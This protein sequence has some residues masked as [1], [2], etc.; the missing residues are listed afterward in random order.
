VSF[1]ELFQGF[2]HD[3]VKAD[4]ED[5]EANKKQLGFGDVEGDGWFFGRSRSVPRR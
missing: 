5:S 3:R 1:Q 2:F 4:K